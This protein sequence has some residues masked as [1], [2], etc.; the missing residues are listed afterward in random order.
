MAIGSFGRALGQIAKE[1]VTGSV[2][3]FASGVKGAFLSEMPGITSAY[4]FAKDVRGRMADQGTNVVA[5]EQRTGNLISLEMVRQL[6]QLNLNVFRQ[7]M[8]S[9]Q[10]AKADR[11]K[12][13][14][15]EEMEREKSLRD[16]AL[17][18]AIKDIGKNFKFGGKPSTTEGG[19]G[20]GLG[21]RLLTSIVGGAI[22]SFLGKGIA[23]VLAA[24][25]IGVKAILAAIA[26]IA[27]KIG[28]QSLGG[29][30]KGG[31]GAPVPNRPGRSARTQP[32]I[33]KGQPGAGRFAKAAPR[34]AATGIRAGFA[35]A[36]LA[37]RTNPFTMLLGAGLLLPE[38]LEMM[39][40][41]PYGAMA[42]FFFP[43]A[44]GATNQKSSTSSSNDYLKKVIQVES[45][46]RSN[47]QA[48]TSSAYGLGQFTKGTFES[49]ATNSPKDS[50]LYGKSFEDY[51]KSEELQIAALKALTDQNR[52]RLVKSGLPTDDAS[53]YLA[54]F[55]GA[56]AALKVLQSNNS[57]DLRSVLPASYF[58]ANPAVFGNL[59]TVG[60]LK[61]WAARKMSGPVGKKAAAAASTV[62]RATLLKGS[63]SVKL[64]PLV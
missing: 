48:S 14:F 28:L 56:G 49:L 12:G 39:G 10:Q 9:S 50:I 16:N 60:D 25:A 42:D 30:G 44:Q 32:R 11:L 54:H 62:V 33:P 40:Y 17:L 5:K 37:L 18:N 26:A 6:K 23:S 21:A 27:A 1:S 52:S 19:G 24:L 15:A 35:G 51:K 63:C 61:A 3:G 7:T 4:G 46:G 2:K 8:F 43:P 59:K 13:M 58:T 34:A 53:L 57:T 36:G 29:F 20:L 22:G 47:A 38:V 55:L 31:R 41:D 45:G 64:Q